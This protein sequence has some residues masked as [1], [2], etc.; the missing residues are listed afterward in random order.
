MKIKLLLST[1]LTVSLYTSTQASLVNKVK[2]DY[3]SSDYAKTKYPIVLVHG[4]SGFSRLGTDGLGI[5]Y[6]YQIVPDLARNGGNIWTS[7]VSPFNSTE[8]RGEQLLQQID[9]VIAITGQPKVNLIGHSHGGPTI[10]YIEGVAPEKVASLTAV[11]G[12]MQ[13]AEFADN[14]LK[15][16]T[17]AAKTI[18]TYNMQGD[19]T[20]FFE[21]APELKNDARAALTS[22]GIKSSTEFNKKYGSAAIP[23][24]C[25]IPSSG[26]KITPNGIYHY[27]WSGNQQVTN[28]F[29]IIDTAQVIAT[30]QTIGTTN[31]DGI[32]SSCTMNYGQVIRNDY[33]HNHYDAINQYFGLRGLFSQD[34]VAIFRQHANRLKLDGL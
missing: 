4:M 32:L 34:P 33:S 11:A 19:M 22:L 28:I 26:Q 27:S 29:D 21:G 30:I 6:W 16:P 2:A 9:E 17:S 3:I 7:S 8:I 23:K 18:A 31:N 14:L 25:N 15:D 13:G 24:N 20:S 5:D 1:L 10:Q 12:A